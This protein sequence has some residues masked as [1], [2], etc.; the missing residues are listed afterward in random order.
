[1]G[2][3]VHAGS[4]RG[5]RLRAT[6]RFLAAYGRLPTEFDPE[7]A[8][9]LMANITAV[10][11]AKAM[12]FAQGIFIALGDGRAQAQAVYD[13]TGSSRLAQKIEVQAMMQKGMQNG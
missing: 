3:N 2:A 4:S 9:G 12:T 6:A 5:K 8:M 7:T 10:E 1:M 11:S 13:I